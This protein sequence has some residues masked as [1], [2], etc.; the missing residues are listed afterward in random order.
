ME[1]QKSQKQQ[2][3]PQYRGKIENEVQNLSAPEILKTTLEK[4]Q[5]TVGVESFDFLSN[6][7]EGVENM[8]PEKKARKKIFLTDEGTR[9]QDRKDLKNRLKLWVEIIASG[10]DL[11]GMVETCEKEQAESK[12]VYLDNLSHAVEEVKELEESYRTVALFYKN[13]EQ[14]KTNYISMMNASIEQLTDTNISGFSNAVRDELNN[15]YDRLDLRDNYGLL[16]IPGFLGSNQNIAEWGRIA[17]QF[18]VMLVTD[19]RGD[20][21]EDAGDLIDMIEIDRLKGGEDYLSNVILTCNWLVGREKHDLIN[22]EEPLFI[23]P[24]AVLAGRMYGTSVSQVVAGKKFGELIGVQGTMIP[25][26]KSELSKLRELGVV[27][28]VNE[29]G[30]IMAFSDKTLYD[31]EDQKFQT[32]SIVRVYDYLGKVLVDFCNRRAFENFDEKTLKEF[33]NQIT[34]YLESKKWDDKIIE[35]YEIIDLRKEED[36]VFID[37]NLTPLYPAVQFKINL[38]A[39]KE[40]DRFNFKSN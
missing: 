5:S 13:T 31:G 29:W 1:E 30:K 34:K 28:M 40:G 38:E 33:K 9:K 12:K 25:L 22:E 39:E 18:K 32:Y 4:I 11:Y 37:I 27:P 15:N 23:P 24:S 17:H 10:E 35:K 2:G 26:L 16:V 20:M 3:N 14:N 7:I 6:L 8:N 36:K 21:F 19:Y